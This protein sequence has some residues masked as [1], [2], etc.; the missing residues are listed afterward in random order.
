MPDSYRFGAFIS[1]RH[2]EPDRAVARWLHGALETYRPPAP[3]KSSVTPIRLGRVFRDEEELAASPDLSALI[4][5][6]LIDSDALIIVCSRRT[7]GSR[8]VNAEIERFCELGK[9]DRLF[10]LLI[11]GTPEESFPP[12][13][14]ALGQEPLAADLRPRAG[15][16]AREQRHTALLKL[17]AGL[18]RVDFD[19]LRRRDEERR[20]RRLTAFAASASAL[21]ALLTGLAIVAALQWRRAED[22]LTLA[23][24]RRLAMLAQIALLQSQRGPGC[25]VCPDA[26]RAPLLAMESLR[27]RPTVEAD[28]VLRQSV[29]NRSG[30]SMSVAEE[31]ELNGLRID[32]AGVLTFE[33]DSNGG[34]AE[35]HLDDVLAKSA[36]GALIARSWEFRPDETARGGVTIE[37]ASGR[38]LKVLP[39]EWA[40]A[41]A[42]FSDDGRWL[43][44]LT[45][46]VSAD[47]EDPSASALPGSAVR[48]WDVE[49]GTLRTQ[50]SWAETG[51]L[52]HAAFAPSGMWLATV[53][54]EPSAEVSGS[55]TRRAIAWPVA[56]TL[57]R[58]IACAGL[59]RNLSE[60]E[61]E[62]FFPGEP[63][64]ETCPGLPKSSE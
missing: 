44:T 37:T 42:R 31:I 10:A 28:A 33:S 60:S 1:Y 3:A 47:S 36:D 27:L 22:E 50:I 15:E 8:W 57:L 55:Y 13:L 53:V 5:Q 17:V 56:P 4:L 26:N 32:N 29:W 48:V 51:G 38:V 52:E 14:M 18:R 59:Q 24:A 61:W 19:T 45:G 11:E 35:V 30:R 41:Q 43:A 63:W 7:P 12:A 16:S 49:Q 62:K 6:A 2:V 39:H 58:N 25:A 54:L 23:K 40:V 9:G 46:R 20:R 21:T 34:I 64:R